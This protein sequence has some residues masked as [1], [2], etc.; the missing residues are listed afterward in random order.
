M[1][2]QDRLRT[3]ARIDHDDATGPLIQTSVSGSL[4][5]LDAA[6]VRRALWHYPAMT[7]GVVARIHWQ[8][9]KLWI[10]KVPFFRKPVPPALLTT[11][12]GTPQP[13]A[14]TP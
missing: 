6:S 1:V 2:T 7:L 11:R 3:L 14:D 4:Q 13:H 9:L 12:A 8:A 5:V 10:K